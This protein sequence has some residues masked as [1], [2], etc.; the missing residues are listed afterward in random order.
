MLTPSDSPAPGRTPSTAQD[1]H[2][3]QL[4]S[5]SN[6]SAVISPLA[7]GNVPQPSPPIHS[8]LSSLP[9]VSQVPTGVSATGI[10]QQTPF[11]APRASSGV[12]WAQFTT[13]AQPASDKDSTGL[14]TFLEPSFAVVTQFTCVSRMSPYQNH[15]D[16]IACALVCLLLI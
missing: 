9:V 6:A 14:P 16:F 13:P 8:Q 12:Q 7:P 10:Q 5:A 3:T 15:L 2:L 11:L 1:G 4:D